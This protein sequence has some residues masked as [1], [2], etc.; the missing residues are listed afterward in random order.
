MKSTITALRASAEID[1]YLMTVN[2]MSSS[3]LCFYEKYKL[4]ES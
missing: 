3:A 2:F 1:V 4:C